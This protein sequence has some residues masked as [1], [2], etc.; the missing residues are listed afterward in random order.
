MIDL[1]NQ[2]RD[3][4]DHSNYFRPSP[5]QNIFEA[6]IDAVPSYE[7]FFAPKQGAGPP[8]FSFLF[9]SFFK[10]GAESLRQNVKC[11]ITN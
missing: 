8:L 2:L 5:R 3:R 1:S 7:I 11:L 4:V 6:L 10:K 9:F